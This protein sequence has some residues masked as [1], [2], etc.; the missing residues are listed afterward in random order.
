MGAPRLPSRLSCE[1][2]GK[3]C[4]EGSRPALGGPSHSLRVWG[5]HYSSE[6]GHLATA[7]SAAEEPDPACLGWP[8]WTQL[9]RRTKWWGTGRWGRR[10]AI[11]ALESGRPTLTCS[12][13]S[14]K[15]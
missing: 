7:G 14:G 8:S 10:G 2:R 12:V 11:W 4:R 9:S 1:S 5:I 13:N 3:V 15:P 6:G